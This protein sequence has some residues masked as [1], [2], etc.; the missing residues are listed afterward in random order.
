MRHRLSCFDGI[1][2]SGMC[3]A[4]VDV[5]VDRTNAGLGP[6]RARDRLCMDALPLAIRK[7]SHPP[8]GRGCWNAERAAKLCR[9]QRS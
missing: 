1:A 4:V 8:M 5:V 3:R 9:Y 6:E 2:V 7:R